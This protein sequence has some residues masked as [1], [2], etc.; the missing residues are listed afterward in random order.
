[1][2]FGLF[3]KYAELYP[4][5]IAN[6]AIINEIFTLDLQRLL[7]AKIAAGSFVS[8]L[9]SVLF[10]IGLELFCP[11]SEV[12]VAKIDAGSFVSSLLSV[13]FSIDEARK[14]VSP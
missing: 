14:F 3:Q 13:L 9:L 1:M 4:K 8:S 2:H 10:S 11:A 5:N 7:V 12:L 6:N